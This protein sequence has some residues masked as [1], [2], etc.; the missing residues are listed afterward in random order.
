MQWMPLPASRS[1]A[2]A[3]QLLEGAA[4]L[5]HE[6]VV[7]LFG[8]RGVLLDLFARHGHGIVAVV[9]DEA[10]GRGELFLPSIL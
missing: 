7:E 1:S 8:S 3:T 9:A 4:H 2:Q 6:D 10:L 5:A